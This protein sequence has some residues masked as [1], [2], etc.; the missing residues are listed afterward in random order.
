MTFTD[1]R[2]VMDQRA[3]VSLDELSVW[4]R[5]FDSSAPQLL[6]SGPSAVGKTLLARALADA[7]ATPNVPDRVRVVQMHPGVGYE[8]L[9]CGIFERAVNGRRVSEHVDGALVSM[10]RAVQ[11]DG[12]RRV[13]VL[14]D[15]HH[16]DV[17]TVLGEM[18]PLL[19]DRDRG[20]GEP[21]IDLLHERGFSL[22]AG[23]AIIAT[24]LTQPSAA[25]RSE[26]SWRRRFSCVELAPSA[27]VLAR[28]YVDAPNEVP[29]LVDGFL[30]LNTIVEVAFGPAH[31]IGHGVFMVP[32]MTH[33]R[34]RA[35][36]DH[37]V[38][39]SLA[40]VSR[41]HPAADRLDAMRF[42]PSLA[43]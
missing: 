28:H 24:S 8:H 5:V 16:V 2:P 15:L 31:M 40:T 13:L 19:D 42:W 41:G 12:A 26:M 25:L 23:L 27:D 21:N 1:A 36:W 6:L 4:M 30:W 17:P 29:D 3:H 7:V 22:P 18:I 34:L 9:V 33:E 38:M 20:D 37:Q 10:A 14:D 32:H 39:P 11:R 35:V 43:A